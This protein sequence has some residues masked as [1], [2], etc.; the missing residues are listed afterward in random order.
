M[1][2]SNNSF[3][4]PVF[5]PDPPSSSI[6]IQQPLPNNNNYNPQ[7]S[8]NQNYMQQPMP[9]LKGIIDPI[10]AMNTTLALMAKA[11]KLNYSTPIN[12]NQ[13][14]S[15][16][17]RNRQIAQPA[18]NLGQDNQM[19]MVGG[20]GGISLDKDW[21]ILLGTAQSDQ[22]EGMQLIF[23]LLIAQKEEAGIQLQA[24]EFDLM[25]AAADLDEIEEVNANCILM[26]NLQQ[27]STSGTQTNTA[28]VI[29]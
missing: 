15:S 4:Y 21:V 17:P 28:P 20:N 22:G 10:A 12:N 16:N 9:N 2:N 19:Q 13:K 3:K 14:I 25:V 27:A 18:M 23:K 8:F 11:F 5:H 7:P 24:E 1:A 26:A 29:R 6:Y